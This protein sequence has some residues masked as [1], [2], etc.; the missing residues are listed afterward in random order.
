MHSSTLSVIE[1]ELYF[2]MEISGQR[3]TRVPWVQ[4][5]KELQN[6]LIA[7]GDCKWMNQKSKV[8]IAVIA[9]FLCQC[10]QKA[11]RVIRV[12]NP[13]RYQYFFKICLS[14]LGVF[15][16][17]H[18]TSIPSTHSDVETETIA[19]GIGLKHCHQFSQ[20]PSLIMNADQLPSFEFE[21]LRP[22]RIQVGYYSKLNVDTQQSW[23]SIRE[24]HV[25]KT[26]EIFFFKTLANE[27]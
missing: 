26:P 19:R 6:E 14:R 27:D 22:L 5:W 9:F 24:K 12:M 25:V 10:L 23:S 4:F 16:L 20:T 21:L 2:K 18:N 7:R 17:A 3:F 1:S 8:Y 13:Q 15:T 11:K